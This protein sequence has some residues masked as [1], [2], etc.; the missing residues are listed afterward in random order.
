MTDRK[1]QTRMAGT[2][3]DDWNQA[4][5]EFYGSLNVDMQRQV[6]AQWHFPKANDPAVWRQKMEQQI[7]NGVPPHIASGIATGRLE[8]RTDPVNGAHTVIDKS[9]GQPMN[10]GVGA[11]APATPAAPAASAVAPTTVPDDVDYTSALGGEGLVGL[12]ANTV[13][14]LF[15][16]KLPAPEAERASQA[17]TNLQVRTQAVL[18]NSIPG[19]PSNYLMQQFERLT[20]TPGSLTQ[21]PAR[22]RERLGQTRDLIRRAIE[23]SQA[24]IDNKQNFS[25]AQL[26]KARE[27]ILSYESLLRDYETILQSFDG[28]GVI[29]LRN[30]QPLW[31]PEIA[32]LIEGHGQPRH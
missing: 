24:V 8:I 1:A 30:E 16:G 6:L 5:R 26:T 31:S 27:N 28:E 11:G 3:P 22:A 2:I 10:Y 17:L 12:V 19:R 13:V 15:G 23:E 32:A 25:P 4:Q 9:T 14:D 7:A 29:D 20:V 18:Q 21:G